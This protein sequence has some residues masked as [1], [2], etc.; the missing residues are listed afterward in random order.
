MASKAWK[1]FKLIHSYLLAIRDNTD[2]LTGWKNLT[3][4]SR[5]NIDDL[6]EP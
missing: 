3:L 2:T 6:W 5:T 1:E 4:L